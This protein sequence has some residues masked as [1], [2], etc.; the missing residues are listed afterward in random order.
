PESDSDRRRKREELAK[1]HGDFD[2]NSA[3]WK[4]V[5]ATNYLNGVEAALQ[6]HH[7]VDDAVVNIGYSRDLMQILEKSKIDHELFE[8]ATG[9]HNITGTNFTKAMQRSG[10]FLRDY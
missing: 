7:A 2:P 9:G 1:A 10:E 8:Y 3:F 4:Q 6:V 5:P